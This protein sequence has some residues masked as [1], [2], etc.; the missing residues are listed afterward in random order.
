MESRVQQL[1]FCV[2]LCLLALATFLVSWQ[3]LAD[4]FHRSGRLGQLCQGHALVCESGDLQDSLR[5]IDSLDGVEENLINW[6][7]HFVGSVF[8][9]LTT[10]LAALACFLPLG[11]VT[12]LV[13]VSFLATCVAFR[14]QNSFHNAHVAK[15]TR[16][17]RRDCLQKLAGASSV[18][19]KNY[20]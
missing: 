1:S 5:A 14:Y 15:H 8:V 11:N 17:A 18:L 9:A 4:V 20:Y 13:L 3:E 19:K 7:T 16:E 10:L 6:R 2:F 12:L